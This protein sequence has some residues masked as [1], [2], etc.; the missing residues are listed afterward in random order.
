MAKKA[1]LFPN[2]FPKFPSA[3]APQY[4]LQVKKREGKTAELE[5]QRGRGNAQQQEHPKKPPCHHPHRRISPF[6]P[7]FPPIFLPEFVFFF[8]N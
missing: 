8:Q 6:F 2:V 5:A 4:S 3:F 7:F 1:Q